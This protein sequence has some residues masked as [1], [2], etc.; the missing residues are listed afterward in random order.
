MAGSGE[1]EREDGA[2]IADSECAW[3]SEW[4][5][6]VQRGATARS[7]GRFTSEESYKLRVK[8]RGKQEQL[9]TKTR[10]V[11]SRSRMRHP[12]AR[13]ERPR[14]VEVSEIDGNVDLLRRL[15]YTRV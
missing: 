15:F 9:S 12:P 4:I 11:G 3:A 2:D 7:E 1:G 13:I 14:E 5:W 6:L 10:K 8:L